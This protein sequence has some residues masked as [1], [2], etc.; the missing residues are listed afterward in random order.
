MALYNPK[1]YEFN[2][3]DQYLTPQGDFG[4]DSGGFRSGST[5]Q[6]DEG[7][8]QE[9]PGLKY[10][11]YDARDLP[12]E[13]GG[14][15]VGPNQY[16]AYDQKLPSPAPSSDFSMIQPRGETPQQAKQPSTT[17]S[18]YPTTTRPSSYGSSP[19]SEKSYSGQLSSLPYGTKSTWQPGA[20]NT[21]PVMGGLPAYNLPEMN[22]GRI[23]E[24][25]ELGMGPG[26][27][28]LREGLSR[29]L[30]ESRYSTNPNVKAMGMKSA[31]SGYGTGIT[32]IRSG[33]SREALNQYMPEYAA[34]IGKSQ[35]EYQ[36][37]VQRVRDQFTADLENYFKKGTQVQT[38]IEGRRPQ[39][40]PA[41]AAKWGV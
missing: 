15:Q 41:Y 1:D 34:Q 40:D 7:Y 23:G 16:I 30:L 18:N 33:A 24:L 31:L 26:M 6:F 19:S 38:P 21:M 4:F 9:Y 28:K 25:T 20:G 11:G 32:D 27:G 12:K 22:R 39:Q 8:S 5:P 37:N 3:K 36:T 17:M 35:S 10:M 2:I 29:A 13:A 14:K